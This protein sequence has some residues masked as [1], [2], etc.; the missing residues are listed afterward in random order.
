MGA[1]LIFF[2]FFFFLFFSKMLFATEQYPIQTPIS[3][4]WDGI[5][6]SDEQFPMYSMILYFADGASSDA[7]GREGETQMM[8]SLLGA[9]TDQFN[10]REISEELEFYATSISTNVFHEYS[11]LSINGPL[12]DIK[13]VF[14][15]ICHLIKKA[16]FPQTEILKTVSRF[17]SSLTNITQSPSELAER[18]FRQVSMENT[19]Y[20]HDMSGT[21]KSVEQIKSE[22][23]KEKL[24][25]FRTEVKKKLYI[26]G[27]KG[28]L[29]LEKILFDD[30][31]FENKK[32]QFVRINQFNE[33]NLPV[34]NE[35]SP[36][37]ITFVPIEGLNQAQ[38]RIGS[39]IFS[40][41]L[42][43]PHL[44]QATS[45]FLGGG[46]TSQLMQELRVKRGLTYSVSGSIS[47]QRDY[48][49]SRISTFTK[50]ETLNET[51]QVIQATLEKISSGTFNQEEFER[52]LKFIQGNM[53]LE[54][55][56]SA[57]HLEKLMYYDHIKVP[58]EE[59]YQFNHLIKKLQ[60]LEIA[61]QAKKVFD[62]NKLDIIIIGAPEL[63]K[64]LMI[65]VVKN[66]NQNQEFQQ[67]VPSE[68]NKLNRVVVKRNWKEFL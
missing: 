38:I 21:F 28:A 46:F 36:N 52:T 63:E 2:I 54:L 29:Q 1:K 49:R 66:Q 11:T 14:K 15:M 57:D 58:L 67:K 53:I 48:G 16:E 61:E 64:Q 24:K 25:Y 43:A 60:S 5:W 65:D 12:K 34:K 62:W 20:E 27:P 32:D 37:K 10:Q 4:N 26:A 18:V 59:F 40:E 51:L 44:L 47:Q 3:K 35:V 13:P 8:F 9:G 68:N 45:S 50:N 7:S 33:S 17:Q 41:K 23:L 30:C 31:G 55:E 6:L 39:F 56:R 42:G 22:H 19:P